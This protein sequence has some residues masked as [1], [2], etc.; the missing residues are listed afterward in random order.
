MPHLV[1]AV[2]RTPNGGTQSTS[3]QDW[4]AAGER[5]GYDPKAR[6]IAAAQNAPLKIFASREGNLAHAVTFL[7]GFPDG[8]F[9]WAQAHLATDAPNTDIAVLKGDATPPRRSGRS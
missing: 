3:A 1:D 2:S 4:F 6:A 8:S 7:P 9:G 5:L